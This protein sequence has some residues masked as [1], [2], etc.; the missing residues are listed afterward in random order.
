MRLSVEKTCHASGWRKNARE[1]FGTE[2]ADIVIEETNALYE[3]LCAE[4]SGIP[5]AK[6]EHMYKNIYP[7]VALYMTLRR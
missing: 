2:R 7:L 4:S 3:R 1:K 5:P 6:R